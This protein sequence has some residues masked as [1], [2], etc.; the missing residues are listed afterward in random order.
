[1]TLSYSGTNLADGVGNVYAGFS[2]DH[3]QRGNSDGRQCNGDYGNASAAD[4]KSVT[5]TFDAD[6]KDGLNL[7]ESGFEVLIDGERCANG[8][9]SSDKCE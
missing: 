3:C 6:I 1:M 9:I 2:V 8:C 4:G 7:D 5:L